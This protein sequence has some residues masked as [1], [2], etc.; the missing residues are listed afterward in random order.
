MPTTVWS[1]F[2]IR[3][4][5][6]ESRSLCI[7]YRANGDGLPRKGVVQTV[8]P[9]GMSW[10]KKD[11]NGSRKAG[12]RIPFWMADVVT[13]VGGLAVHNSKLPVFTHGVSEVDLHS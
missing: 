3:I 13:K 11:G 10:I 8:S 7:M 12:N 4:V 2:Y 6:E 9:G 1:L 5:G